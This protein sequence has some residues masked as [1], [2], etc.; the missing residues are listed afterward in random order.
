MIDENTKKMIGDSEMVLIGLGE[1]FRSTED[2]ERNQRILEA[3]NV[4]SGLLKGKTYFV[5]SQN[6]DDLIFRS[7]LLPFFITEPFGPEER[8]EC[9]E[10]QWKT[11][12]RWLA[13]TLGH[14][15]CILEL[16]VGFTSPHLIRFPFEKTLQ[17]N[18]KSSMVR[19]HEE[20][21][22][23]TEEMEETGRAY[24]VRSSAVSWLLDEMT[25]E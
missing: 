3:Y 22:Q 12:M 2:E 14:H 9:G 15:L 21:P 10:E 13:G 20:F 7:K 6:E 19:V 1:E 24:S 16:G 25:G 8:R 4:L 11:Y 17:L 5:I 23:L 18:L